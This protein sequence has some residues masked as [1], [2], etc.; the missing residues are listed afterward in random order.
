MS[1]PQRPEPLSVYATPEFWDDPHISAQMLA[2][3]LDPGTSAASRTHEF[4][5]RSVDWLCA[6]LDLGPG[7]RVLD[8]GCG[9]GLY[10]ERL[11]RR[12]ISVLGVDASTRSIAHARS[13]AEAEDLPATFVHGNYLDAP[14][15]ADHDAALLI[16]EDFCVLSPTQR[17]H[18]LGRVH[19]ALR[20]GGQ[21]VLDVT[22]AARF[23]EHADGRQEGLEEVTEFWAN[24]PY[25]GVRQTWTYP[26]I[27]LVL[28]HY[29]IEKDGRVREF[30]DWMQCLTPAEAT[31]ELEAAGFE[32]AELTGDVAGAPFDRESPSFAVRAIRPS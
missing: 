7:S 25:R 15:G 18:L 32:I 24:R 5:D 19:T 8:L 26:G 29:T 12:G 17:A 10:A 16:Y 3:H 11:A 9:P 31:A 23:A 14:L 6:V 28:D 22:S 27:R 30:W 13:V 2:H 20:P 1:E 21:F 4:I